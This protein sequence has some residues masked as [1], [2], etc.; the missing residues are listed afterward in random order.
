[1]SSFLCA[2]GKEAIKASGLGGIEQQVGAWTWVWALTSPL[3][4][5][6][7]L[8]QITYLCLAFAFLSV[9]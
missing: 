1:M 3:P 2:K 6:C 4:H 7:D 5:P 8:G 9:E